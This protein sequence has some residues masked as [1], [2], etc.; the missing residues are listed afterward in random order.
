VPEKPFLIHFHGASTYDSHERVR[1]VRELRQWKNA[2]GAVSTIDLMKT[3]LPWLP[4]PYD[5]DRLYAMKKPDPGLPIRIV[6]A[7]TNRALK[8]TAALITAVNDLQIEGYPVELDLIEGVTWAECLRRKATADIYFDQTVLGYGCNALEA[9]S[10]GIPVIAGATDDILGMMLDV[11]GS[12]PFYVTDE[13]EIKSAIRHMVEDPELRQK[14]ADRG[15]Q[16]VR[17]FHDYPAVRDRFAQW[18]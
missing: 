10:M 13:P 17:R 3:G 11:I 1:Y 6:H 7:P 9:W 5:V 12:L 2:Q 18:L 8:S 14:W 16:Y 15:H 4:A